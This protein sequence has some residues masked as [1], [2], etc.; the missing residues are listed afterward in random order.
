[1]NWDDLKVLLAVARC[2]SL[3]R[4][5][6]ALGIDQSTAGRRL[7]N[8]EA[9]LGTVLFVRS[10]SGFA[11]TEA[12]EAT[13]GR[14]LEIEARALQLVEELATA[15]SSARGTVRIVGIPWVLDRLV[16]VCLPGFAARHPEI[17]LCLVAAPWPVSLASVEPVI[18]LWLGVP[19]R[20]SEFTVKLGDVPYAVY[21]ATGR[22][23]ESL[24]WAAIW[25][26]DA[27]AR[28]PLFLDRSG[29]PVTAPRL[30]ATDSS[31]LLAYVEGGLARALLPICM[32]AGCRGI[33]RVTSGPPDYVA[34]LH[35]HLHPDTVQSPRIQTVMA[36]LRD[37]F[38]DAFSPRTAVGQEIG[39]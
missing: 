26:E 31:L 37:G 15:D 28:L 5:A 1:V 19:P 10:R 38:A 6:L 18:G 14:A 36:W 3:S 4:A 33:G 2:G 16:R 22:A 23:S 35:M 25:A 39:A 32:A 20:D 9:A 11:A 7:A 21:A 12:G 13:I 8:L 27:P 17:E 29:A 30:T 24:D 34:G